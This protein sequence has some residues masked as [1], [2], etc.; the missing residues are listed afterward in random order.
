MKPGKTNSSGFTLIELLV[1]I[2]IIAILAAL[3]LPT[4]SSAKA[5]AQKTSCMN[6][7]KQLSIAWTIYNGEN[8]GKIPSCVPFISR[9]MGNSNAW[10]LGVSSPTNWPDPF[11]VVDTGVLDATNQNAISRGTLF[12]CA[13]AVG[14]Y[15]CPAD[16][17]AENGVPYVRSYS[18]NNWMNGV[19]FASIDSYDLDATHRLFQ[20]ESSITMPS[21]LFVFID[22]DASTIN[23]AMFVTIMDPAEGFE[24]Q[25]SL[26][27]KTGYPLAFAD[28]HAEVF[29][30]IDDDQDLGKLENAATVLQ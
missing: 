21:Q 12:S 26:R 29:K 14:I 15:R 25:P 11:G 30:F 27:H 10:V 9:G 16:L 23:D 17:R 8:S 3:L 1:V 5:N 2:A 28:G 13:K 19:P 4:L 6:N 20:T 24:D 7:L 18:M 22:E